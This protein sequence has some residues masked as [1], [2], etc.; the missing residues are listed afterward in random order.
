[1]FQSRAQCVVDLYSSMS[2]DGKHV[3]GQLTLGENIAD[4]GGVKL[5]YKVGSSLEP[6][7]HLPTRTCALALAC[8]ARPAMASG[9]EDGGSAARLVG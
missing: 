2:L 4:I 8:Y 9:E 5:A 3:N 6:P 7:S 1:M